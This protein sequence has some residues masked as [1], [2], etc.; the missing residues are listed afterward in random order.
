ME[1]VY[2]VEGHRAYEFDYVIAVCKDEKTAEKIA[3]DTDED[4]VTISEHVL[5]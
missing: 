5:Q 2:I 3:N 1:K 4:S